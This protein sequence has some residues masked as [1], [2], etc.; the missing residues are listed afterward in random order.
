MF[1][2]RASFNTLSFRRG[3]DAHTTVVRGM[4]IVHLFKSMYRVSI[5]EFLPHSIAHKLAGMS[6][7]L[8]MSY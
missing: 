3:L 8:V 2:V 1:L 4:S 6:L 5:A 7:L